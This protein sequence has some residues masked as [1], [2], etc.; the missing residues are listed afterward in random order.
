MAGGVAPAAC[1]VSTP[2]EPVC[3]DAAFP[4]PAWCLVTHLPRVLLVSRRQARIKGQKKAVN[5][6][7]HWARLAF[8]QSRPLFASKLQCSICQCCP[9]VGGEERTR[10]SDKVAL[11]GGDG[12]THTVPQPV[13]LLASGPILPGHQTG[14]LQSAVASPTI[15]EASQSSRP[16]DIIGFH[17]ADIHA[18]SR[19]HH[20]V[21]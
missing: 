2:C 5:G 14:G 11:L 16:T 3:L 7:A 21:C 17:S 6:R 12:A 13:K 20:G 8:G 1:R 4:A 10:R 19:H 15:N 18:R 9:K